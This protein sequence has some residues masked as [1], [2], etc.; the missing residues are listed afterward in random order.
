MTMVSTSLRSI[1]AASAR[2]AF[3]CG[4]A[5]DMEGAEGEYPICFAQRGDKHPSCHSG[6][7]VEAGSGA[8]GKQAVCYDE[9]NVGPCPMVCCVSKCG[10][11]GPV[12][13]RI[14]G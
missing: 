2:L 4:M 10:G 12:T 1:T 11:I 7:R 5:A 9:I 6:I 8:A 3:A 13:C 14:A